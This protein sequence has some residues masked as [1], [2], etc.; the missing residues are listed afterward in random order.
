[1]F[2]GGNT[3]RGFHSFY[4][5]V[6]GGDGV[7]TYILKGG[8]G[9][10]KSNFMRRLANDI[11]Q[12]GY[13]VEEFYCSS[14]STSLDGVRFPTIGVTLVD[15]TAPHLVDPRHPG[16][17]ETVINLA[18]YWHGKALQKSRADVQ[19]AVPKS[20]FLFR[21]AYAYLQIARQINEEL[22]NYKRELGAIDTVGLNREAAALLASLL[23]NAAPQA[24]PARLRHLFATAIT[25]SGIVNHLPSILAGY[26]RKVFIQGMP[27]SGQAMLVQSVLACAVAKN[28]DVEVFHCA[29]DPHR[30]D[31]ILI[32]DLGIAVCNTS[33]PHSTAVEETDEIIDT[34]PYLA[35][36]KLAPYA[37]EIAMLEDGYQKALAAAIALIVRAKENH[38]YL[39]SLYIPHM[40]FARV[41]A[42]REQ[43]KQQII[44]L[45]GAVDK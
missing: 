7:R 43:V 15:G 2:L 45:A 38:A 13:D 22:A 5:Q 42:R 20:A 28:Y 9:T 29:L 3:G 4:D 26:P 23:A 12:L 18:D 27:D 17:I 19:A 32:P 11:G 34:S 1:M 41:D 21:R 35:T 25:P 6:V 36:E 14:D 30:V 16:V 33:P 8:P 44:C 40:D 10:G 24:Q 39:E 37:N 31:H